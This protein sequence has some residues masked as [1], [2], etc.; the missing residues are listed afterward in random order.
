MNIYALRTTIGQEKAAARMIAK[1]ATEGRSRVVSVLVPDALKGY[2]FVE[3]ESIEDIEKI[4]VNIPSVRKRPV[5]DQ[6]VPIEE[7]SNILVPRPAIEGIKVGDIVEVTMG[8]FRGARAKITKVDSGREEVT[9][10]LLDSDIPIP[11]K[12]HADYVR[13]IDSG[14]REDVGFGT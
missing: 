3:A 10:E 13:V 14:G 11:V 2:I 8:P 4:T 7:L 5:K 6:P 12:L 1:R 9:V